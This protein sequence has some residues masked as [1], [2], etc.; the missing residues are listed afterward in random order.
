MFEVE[1]EQ[2]IKMGMS[3]KYVSI[4]LKVFMI[5]TF[6]KGFK[7]IFLFLLLKIKTT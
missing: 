2:L 7:G 4:Y 6:D 5:D 1:L 3:K